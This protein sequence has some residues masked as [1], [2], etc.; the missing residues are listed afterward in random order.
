[1]LTRSAYGPGARLTLGAPGSTITPFATPSASPAPPSVSVKVIW[2]GPLTVLGYGTHWL[3]RSFQY[4]DA[5]LG[6]CTCICTRGTGE[7]DTAV[8]SQR[9]RGKREL[10]VTT[11]ERPTAGVEGPTPAHR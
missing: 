2:F 4:P 6:S 5:A 7:H 1:M 3:L 8:L 11:D 10:I 9:C